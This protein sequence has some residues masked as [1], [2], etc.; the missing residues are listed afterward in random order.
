MQKAQENTI[1][2]YKVA[3]A[4]GCSRG[5]LRA[6]ISASPE[7][8]PLL[9]ALPPEGQAQHARDLEAVALAAQQVLAFADEPIEYVHFPRTAVVSL[10][11][12]MEDG[13]AI[14]GASVGNHG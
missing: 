8:H 2:N 9:Q 10:L 4:P 12:P 14:E 1:K 3:W 13:S 6:V 5:R 7:P 11:V